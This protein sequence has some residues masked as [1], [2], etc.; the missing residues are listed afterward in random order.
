MEQ[1]ATEERLLRYMRGYIMQVI[2]GILF[3]DASDSRVHFR[4]LPLLKDLDICGTLSWGLAVLAWLYRQRCHAMEHSQYNLDNAK[5]KNRLRHYKL[6][7]NG[8]SI[9][10]TLY[11]DLQLQGVVPPRITES[12]ASAVVVCPLFCFAIVK[13][14]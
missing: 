7:L 12:E 3:L 10:N 14:H 11:A 1:D 2:R 6:M 4:W 13:W 5:G 8:I 9:L